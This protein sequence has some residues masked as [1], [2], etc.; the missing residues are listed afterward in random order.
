ML[1]CKKESTNKPLVIISHG[2][3]NDKYEG[4]NLALNL[5]LQDYC[6]I[7]FDADKHGERN[8]GSA[9]SVS[10]HSSFTEIMTSVI[11]QNAN[12]I[13]ALVNHCKKDDRI[14]Q[15]RIAMLGISMGAMSIFYTLTKNKDI[16]VAVPIIGSPD[17]VGLEKYA[18]EAN[19]A[20][21]VLSEDEKL[22]I[23]YMEEID[24]YLYLIESENRPMLIMNGEKDDWVPANFS[25]RFYDKVKGRYEKNNTQI[26]FFLSNES[27]YFSNGMRDH[28]IKWL[29]K[30]L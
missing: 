10:S 5:A 19:S 17:F 14:D 13:N 6:V 23:K 7:C 3:G 20:N 11:K 29:N 25:K 16:K 15:S 24:P 27:H 26:E 4:S 30:N 28:T 9:K 18:L 8:D 21:K 22:G 2:A 12:D 1:Y